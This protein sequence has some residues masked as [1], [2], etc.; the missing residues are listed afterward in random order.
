VR[1]IR[2]CLI[3]LFPTNRGTRHIFVNI[4]WSICQAR[5]AR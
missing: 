5:V 1:G 2:A 4:S 3:D